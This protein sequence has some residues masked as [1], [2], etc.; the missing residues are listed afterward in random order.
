[1]PVFGPGIAHMIHANIDCQPIVV[2]SAPSTSK[3]AVS[4]PTALT[5]TVTGTAI[6]TNGD[7]HTDA[8]DLIHWT[9]TVKNVGTNTARNISV[10]DPAQAPSHARATL[11]PRARR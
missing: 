6:D 9:I 4:G 7:G 8:G 11:W 3:T 1:M 2:T 5:V 10:T